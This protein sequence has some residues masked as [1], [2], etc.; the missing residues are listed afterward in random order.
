M[1]EDR[2]TQLLKLRKSYSDRIDILELNRATMG[3]SWPTAQQL[4]LE[5]AQRDRDLADAELHLLSPSADVRA[6][7]SDEARWLLV[8]WRFQVLTKQ[9]QTALKQFERRIVEY[10]IADAQARQQSQLSLRLLL[11]GILVALVVQLVWR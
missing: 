3:P 2:V 5:Q 6:T 1:G 7:T 11:G 8:E 9:V 4:E 10:Q